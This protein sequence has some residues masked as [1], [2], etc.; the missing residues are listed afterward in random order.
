MTKISVVHDKSNPYV[1]I[2]KT[3]INDKNLSWKAKGIFMYAFS[4]PDDWTFYAKDI[5]NHGT[6][7]RESVNSGL[8]ELED[9]G[10]LVR[11]EIR[12]EKG[13]YDGTDWLIYELPQTQELNKKVPQTGFQMAVSQT[14]ANPPLLINE[15]ELIKKD[16]QQEKQKPAAAVVV[17][18]SLN[19]LKI[20]DSLKQ[21]LSSK[22]SQQEIDRAVMRVLEWKTRDCDAKAIRTVLEKKDEW[23]DNTKST[24]E[25]NKQDF[26]KTLQK[27]D[28]IKKKGYQIIVGRDYI[29]F[30]ST[31]NCITYHISDSNFEIGAQQ[32]LDK[33]FE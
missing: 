30:S 23:D 24:K 12:N 11:Q 33:L 22:Y 13:Q 9:H 31:A 4:K 18:S 20:N 29:E 1:I 8:K 25:K 14:T 19:Q 27:Y 10:Y 17:F 5:I 21:E 28:G 15:E 6:D 32:F 3:I 2:N 26:F 16:K 7:G